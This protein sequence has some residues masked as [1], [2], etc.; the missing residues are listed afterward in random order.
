MR[1][2][3]GSLWTPNSRSRKPYELP[4]SAPLLDQR[5]EKNPRAS[6]VV[7]TSLNT[8]RVAYSAATMAMVNEMMNALVAASTRPGE[9]RAAAAANNGTAAISRH[10]AK[11]V[12]EALVSERV[13]LTR[14]RRAAHARTRAGPCGSDL[15]VSRT[16]KIYTKR[17][18]TRRRFRDRAPAFRHVRVG[19]RDAPALSVDRRRAVG[20]HRLDARASPVRRSAGGPARSGVRWR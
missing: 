16:L 6:A 11:E 15:R 17:C 7:V 20:R 3:P 2:V 9:L 13:L 12:L 8:H 19:G 10:S 4:R 5:L 1:N 18:E 14:S